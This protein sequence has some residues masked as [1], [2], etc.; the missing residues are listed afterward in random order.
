MVIAEGP[1][2]SKGR[3]WGGNVRASSIMLVGTMCAL[4]CRYT[5]L[6]R[7]AH[8]LVSGPGFRVDGL[9]ISN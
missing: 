3:E 7:G 4:V 2:L 9:L 8:N 1:Q 6:R 5:V